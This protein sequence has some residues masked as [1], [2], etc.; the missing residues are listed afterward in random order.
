MR[1]AIVALAALPALLAGCTAATGY[2]LPA[3]TPSS[4]GT[5]VDDLAATTGDDAR[6]TPPRRLGTAQRVTASGA[7]LESTVFAVDQNGAPDSMPRGGGHWV[8]ADV[9]TGLLASDAPA[10]VGVAGWSV[11]DG[12]NRRSPAA[13][14]L[15]DP[16]FPDP[17]YP[18][19]RT[20]S[21]GQCVRGWLMFP[22]GFKAVVT[23][24]TYAADP[25]VA[26]SAS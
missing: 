16:S 17:R 6:S 10:A 22:A 25:S 2:S 7:R 12:A 1:S 9:R 23:A 14:D 20:L 26:W 8:A 4:V 11:V 5:P 19:A 24:V 18:V 13:T 15:A 3:D 21:A